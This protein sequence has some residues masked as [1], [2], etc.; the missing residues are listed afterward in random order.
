MNNEEFWVASLFVRAILLTAHPIICCVC[1]KYLID[2][3]GCSR[4]LLSCFRRSQKINVV[5]C[6]SNIY[7]GCF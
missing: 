1:T 4:Q 2:Q 3:S 6:Y 7:A 5:S